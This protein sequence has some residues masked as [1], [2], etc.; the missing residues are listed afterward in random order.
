M[1]ATSATGKSAAG[2]LYVVATPI[3]NPEDITLRAI[4]VLGEVDWVA[5][6]DTRC[7]RRLLKH[8]GLSAPLISFY[9]HNEQRRTGELIRRL[10][11]G[12]SGALVSNAGT[13]T[14]SDPGYRLVTAAAKEGIPVVPVPG[15]TAAAAALSA[16]GLPTDAFVFVGFPP[17]KPKALHRFL[18]RLAAEEKTLIFYESPVRILSFLEAA[19]KVFSDRRAVLAREM[20]KPHEEFLRGRL[21][22]IRGALSDRDAVKGECTLLVAGASDAGPPSADDLAEAVRSALDAGMS[23][24]EAAKTIAG[25]YRLPKARV[26]ETALALKKNRH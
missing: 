8:H 7:T 13:P 3:G 1:T 2:T 16:S 17:K 19:E 20:T 24:S 4:R 21:S 10:A 5:A 12:S 22:A 23:V 9:E 6:E 15:P 26:Y 11:E 18:E 25:R 14:V